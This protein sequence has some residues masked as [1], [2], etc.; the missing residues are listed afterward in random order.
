MLLR[1]VR[2]KLFR[3]RRCIPVSLSTRFAFRL[4]PELQVI[5]FRLPR[6][7]PF[8]IG[9]LPNGFFA[10]SSFFVIV[11]H[12]ATLPKTLKCLRSIPSFPEFHPSDNKAADVVKNCQP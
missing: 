5:S 7:F 9:V 8:A 12:D 6:L 2:G 3:F 10:R 4:K 11:G 1:F